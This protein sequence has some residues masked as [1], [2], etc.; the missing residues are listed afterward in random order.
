MAP[1][2]W[3]GMAGMALGLLS[4]V[5]MFRLRARQSTV[6]REVEQEVEKTSVVLA[7]WKN[8]CEAKDK[9]LQ[10]KEIEL[11][12]MHTELTTERTHHSSEMAKERELRGQCERQVARLEG[13]LA[14]LISP[15]LPHA[16]MNIT[17]AHVEKVTVKGD[18]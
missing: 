12:R 10:D 17:E 6:E 4:T 11:T 18:E 15:G 13:Q 8:I 1:N 9:Q 16:E 3:I 5:W 7:S 2:D 14:A